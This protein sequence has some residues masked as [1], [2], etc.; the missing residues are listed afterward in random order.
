MSRPRL[1]LLSGGSL[2]GQNVLASL[3]DWRRRSHVAAMTSEPDEPAVF[4][5]DAVYLA[6]E[7][8]ARAHEFALRFDEV[9]AH[10]SPD[11]VIP[12]RDDDVSFLSAERAR[13]PALAARLLC[14]DAEVAAAMLDKLRSAEFSARHGLPFAP[15]ITADRGEDAVRRFAAEHG[16]PLIAKPRRGF[17]SRGVRLIVEPAQIGPAC[18]QTDTVLQKYFGNAG[19]VRRL[20]ADITARGLPL[21]HSLEDTK[22]SLQASIAPDGAVSGVFASDNLM[23]MGRSERVRVVEDSE[24]LATARR[25][26]D[27]FSRDGWRGPLN[28]QCH[29]DT[30]GVL[31]IYEYNG[32]FTG[33]TA[34]RQW[35]GFDEVGLV[36]R[37]WV[38]LDLPAATDTPA[39]EVIRTLVSRVRRPAHVERLRR[40]GYWETPEA[41]RTTRAGA[42]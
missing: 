13:R 2:V 38:G 16:F 33:A 18:A 7:V 8:G 15:T 4:D 35:L 22:L 3:G 10:C 19:A 42:P 1:L 26:A 27:V 9:M 41:P 29:R 12:C 28:I 39:R 24:V 37:D 34:A 36:L 6:P 20:A 40:D 25:W 31:T 5:F 17:A 21:F 30:S 23:R 14:G 11:L 32:R